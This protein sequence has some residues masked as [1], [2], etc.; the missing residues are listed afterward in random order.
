MSPKYLLSLDLGGSGGRCLLLHSE[1]SAVVSTS[2]PWSFTPAPEAGGFAFDLGCEQR[3]QALCRLAREAL[4]KAGAGPEDVAG[5]ATTSMRHGLVLLGPAGQV[6]M[7]CPNKDA[8]AVSESMDLGG[9]RGEEFYRRTGHWPN[10]ILAASRLLWVKKEHPE[11]LE[12]A[13]LLTVSDW[14][15]Y[16][17]CGVTAVEPSQAAESGLF[18]LASQGWAFDLIQS[19]DL[20]ASL[21]P[22]LVPAGTRLGILADGPAAQLGLRAGIPVSVGGSDTQCGLLGLGITAAG[23][24]GI[25]AG[26]TTPLMVT[27]PRPITD[28]NNRTWTGVH[29]LPGVYELESNV[30]AMGSSLEWL[31][32]VLYPDSPAPVAALCGEAALAAPGAG[33]IISTLGTQLFNGADMALPVDGLTFSTMSTPP[34]ASGRA[35]LARAALEGMACGIRVNLD[36][37]L[38]VAGIRPERLYLGGGMTRSA[39]FAQVVA[40]V[41]GMPVLVGDYYDSTGIGAALCAAVGAGLYPGLPAAAKA[42]ARVHLVQPSAAAEVY[43]GLYPAWN[44]HRQQRAP[45]DQVAQDAI[46]ESMQSAAGESSVMGEPTF[47]P[48]SYVSA[49]AGDEAIAMLR[50]LG[51]VTYASYSEGG[52]VLSGDEL[53]ETLQGYQVFVTEVDMVDAPVL[54]KA[55]DLRVVVVC[56]GNPVN[57]D[58]PA[59]TA[60][61]VPVINTP[62]RNADAV[63]DLAIGL[64]LMLL[65]KLDKAAAFLRQPGGEAGDLGRMG[66]AYF[67]FKG[68]ELWHKTVGV[69]GGGAIGKKV[70]RR[71]L[72]FEARVLVYDPYLS[73]EQAAVAGATQV[74]F[75][76]LLE[77]SDIVT[78]HVPANDETTGMMN[79]AAFARMKPGAFLVNTARAAVVDNNALIG[80][81]RSGRLGGAAL[82]VFPIEPPGADDP[83]LAFENVIATPHI[84]GNTSE[85]GIHQGAIIVD[86]LKRLLRGQKPRY[87]LNPEALE[88]FHWS[89]ER[90]QNVA[91]LE[92][93][94]KGPGPGMTDLDLKEKQTAALAAGGP[95]KSGGL[96]GGLR[97]LLG[98]KGKEVSAE[99]STGQTSTTAAPLQKEEPAPQAEA[100][101]VAPLPVHTE[102]AVATGPAAPSFERF[103]RIIAR[104]LELLNSDADAQAFARGKNVVFQFTLKDAGYAF[105]MS[106]VD[107]KAT[108]G[109]ENLPAKPD[110]IVKTTAATIDGLFTGRL[111][112]MQAFKTGK[113]SVSGNMLKAAA[114]QKLNFNR[115]YGQARAEIGDPGDLSAPAGGTA[116][117]APPA[118]PAA[119]PSP[120]QVAP[121]A[122]GGQPAAPAVLHRVG[123]VRDELLEITNELYQKGWITS[124][125]GNLSVRTDDNPEEIWIT[126]SSIFKGSLRAEIMVRIDLEGNMLNDLPLN[127]STERRVH[128]AIYRARPEVR[129]VIHTHAPFATLMALTGTKWQPISADA[130]F[131]G[132]VPVVSFI[133]PGTPELGDEVAKA[134]GPKGFTAIMQ[135]HGLVVAGTS[136]RRA[137]DLTEAVELT[138]EK[139][140]WCRQL[141]VDPVTISP[142]VAAVLA[143]M[144]TMIS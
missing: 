103:N 42:L 51:D 10:P 122:Q 56:R 124:T 49:N 79:E 105:Y 111:D 38:A 58:I 77:Q 2:I 78:L 55:K 66:Q 119:A 7:A 5:I 71:L 137:A 70:I 68:S 41:A 32:G 85:V 1:T 73:A 11:W 65:R 25:I 15:A 81:L 8:R 45:A 63:A 75:E 126:P 117:K 37:A 17:L 127:A 72:P 128:C 16:R 52:G 130:A 80:A 110:V 76:E 131:F 92:R 47:R 4:A 74:S 108:A 101:T 3:W 28:P 62:G 21:F 115:A 86:E 24:V 144:G 60:A 87:V 138:A 33:G 54:Q 100:R 135:N 57:I 12:S 125:G 18:D 143:E 31:A 82:D 106:F 53:V 107:G 113:L 88:G 118:A 134:M 102:P 64:M 83:L 14:L 112:G 97:R 19:L 43:A 123:D 59:C 140:L 35:S 95:P 139:L 98:G 39:L 116:G 22:K 104:F 84:A 36:Q 29:L 6:R 67:N 109:L 23:Q 48:R 40:D 96:L 9:E 133:M 93:L 120:L 141:G 61:G 94:A 34:A 13:T 27:L 26:S 136:L 69:V 30:G 44:N 121:V 46:I 20:P 142:E 50:E 90:R 114:F 129:A 132:D 89:G 91:A 99:P